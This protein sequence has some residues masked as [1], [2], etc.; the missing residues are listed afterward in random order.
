MNKDKKLEKELSKI[1]SSKTIANLEKAKII[2]G[3]DITPL[4]AQDNLCRTQCYYLCISGCYA[5]NCK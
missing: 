2:G 5:V 1:F 3:D 4:E